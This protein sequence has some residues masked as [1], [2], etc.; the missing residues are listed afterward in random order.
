MINDLIV[1]RD[2]CRTAITADNTSYNRGINFY[3]IS[4]CRLFIEQTRKVWL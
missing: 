2:L 4:V 1:V 3:F